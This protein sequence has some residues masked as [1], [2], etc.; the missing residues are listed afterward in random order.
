MGIV[1]QTT[2]S[3]NTNDTWIAP[4]FGEAVTR[5]ASVISCSWG[6]GSPST[7]INTAIQ[8]AVNN[9]RDGRGCVVLFAA[10]NNNASINYPASNPQ[11]IAVGAST[12]CDTRKRSSSNS[13]QVNPGVSTDPEG[14]SCDGEFWWGSNF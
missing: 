10:G 4:C 7:Q 6:G 2:G 8:N 12:P 1:N 3:F 5:G 9:G 11:V 14:T 13:T